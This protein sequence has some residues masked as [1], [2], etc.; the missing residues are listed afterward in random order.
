[1]AAPRS[2]SGY[3]RGAPRH[4]E[5]DESEASAD[6]ERPDP[7]ERFAQDGFGALERFGAELEAL[8]MG[9]PPR[10]PTPNA[11][12]AQEAAPTT[13]PSSAPASSSLVEVESELNRLLMEQG[14]VVRGHD[15]ARVVGLMSGKDVTW[16]V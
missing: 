7:V 6:R 3:D 15:I 10:R 9:P 12:T 4:D 8:F 11:G 5:A 16:P 13:A 1:E 2:E 14:I